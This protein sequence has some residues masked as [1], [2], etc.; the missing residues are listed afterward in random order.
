MKQLRGEM[1]QYYHKLVPADWWQQ[2]VMGE[3]AKEQT[4]G[5]PDEQRFAVSFEIN[6]RMDEYAAAHPDVSPYR[7]KAVLHETIAELFEPAIFPH[8]PFYFEMGVRPA[9]N[10]GTPHKNFH[11]GSWMFEAR[12][13]NFKRDQAALDRLARRQELCIHTFNDHV[14][15]DHHSVGYTKVL[16]IGLEGLIEEARAAKAGAKTAAELEFLD[17]CESSLNTVIRIAAKFGAAAARAIPTAPDK[18]SA[19][20]LRMIADTAP[21]VPRRP[22][23]TFYEGLAAM[24]FMREVTGSLESIGVSILGHPDR[25]LWP[26]YARDLSEGLIG[27]ESAVDLVARW[28]V[29]TDIKFDLERNRW[30]ETS[31][32]LTLGGCDATGRPV[33]NE[34]TEIFLESHQLHGLINPKLNCRF[35]SNSSEKYL[36]AVAAANLSGHNNIALINDDCLIEANV[37]AGKRLEDC[38]LYGAGGCQETVVEGVEHSAGAY[39]YF[40][41]PQTFRLI[42]DRS[43]ENLKIA[44]LLGITL[45]KPP[46]RFDTFFDKTMD[47]IV[48][49]IRGGADDQRVNGEAWPDVSPAPFFSSTIDDCLKNRKDYTAGG[50]RYN[51][52]GISLVGFGTLVDSL[53]AVKKICYDEE[54]MPVADFLKL[55][56]DGWPDAES[57]RR[58]VIALPKYGHDISEVDILAGRVADCLHKGTLNLKNERGGPFQLSFFVYYG[59]V[60]MGK[61]TGGTPDGRLAGDMFTQ[62]VSPGRV[63]PCNSITEAVKSLS[64]VDFGNYPG[65]AVL[66]VQLPNGR[67]SPETLTAL[68]RTFARLKLPT[69]QISVASSE[70]MRDAQI[71]PQDHQGLT[72]RISGLSARFNCLI[73]EVQDEIIGRAMMT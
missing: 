52:A 51:P 24:L 35:S 73:R 30:P 60:A 69:I 21:E 1:A 8:S 11:A 10:W 58:K 46:A 33:F 31:T 43:R 19:R 22:A 71:H 23:R 36:R 68:L 50:A 62:G 18:T 2:R 70:V 54:A 3:D 12:R 45:P 61:R 25:V 66:D 63:T 13:K 53:F 72:V 20:F 37:R 42:W 5:L 6:R 4:K 47:T 29:H 38:R 55:S 28:M 34:I 67:H 48:K 64:K 16:R 27:R 32:T 41:L 59:F 39:Y 40:N 65:N 49:V 44:R 57:T 14:D 7:L 26:L 15:M 17:A 9:P 56:L